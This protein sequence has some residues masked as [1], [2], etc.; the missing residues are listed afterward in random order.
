MALAQHNGVPTRLL[1][2]SYSPLVALYTAAS[3]IAQ[4]LKQYEEDGVEEM[5]VWGLDCHRLL[6]FRYEFRIVEVSR[7]ENPF[8]RA[9]KGL[10]VLDLRASRVHRG[11]RTSPLNERI[12][13]VFTGVDKAPVLY[14]Y[15]LPIHEAENVLRVLA[16]EGIDRA[17]LT[18]TYD[19]VV[20]HLKK[21][22]G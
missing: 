21:L 8:L 1:D 4:K 5:A 3:D 20:D 15:S 17:H 13:A 12:Q 14:K 19:N 7:A 9:Q 22:S 6:Q 16:L 18:P 10:F 11:L 2:F